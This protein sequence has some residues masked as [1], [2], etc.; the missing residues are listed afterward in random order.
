MNASYDSNQID[1]K[2][3]KARFFQMLI[4]YFFC[5]RWQN[6]APPDH[7]EERACGVA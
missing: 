7:R 4:F 2:L 3:E 6:Y 1:D 5:K